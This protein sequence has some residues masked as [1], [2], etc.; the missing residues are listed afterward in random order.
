[1]SINFNKEAGV[2]MVDLK[3]YTCDD[4]GHDIFVPG[5]ILKRIPGLLSKSGKEESYSI[6]I[7]MCAKCHHVNEDNAPAI[8]RKNK[9]NRYEEE[10]GETSQ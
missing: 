4:C 5:Y 7:F 9:I 8:L 10:S 3:S 1:M 2:S 6:P